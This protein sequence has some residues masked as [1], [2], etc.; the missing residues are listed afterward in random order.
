M[1][2]AT[3]FVMNIE[4]YENCKSASGFT[5]TG[6]FSCGLTDLRATGKQNGCSPP[7]WTGGGFPCPVAGRPG[8]QR[9][10][11]MARL[12]ARAAVCS[13]ERKA[14]RAVRGLRQGGG[15]KPSG[16]RGGRRR[17]RGSL[18]PY[19]DGAGDSG[20]GVYPAERG[21]PPGGYSG[22]RT[23]NDRAGAERP[24]ENSGGTSRPRAVY[25]DL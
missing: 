2:G 6:W 4:R 5:K 9:T 21:A 10:T 17:R 12:I 25:P 11:D 24:V 19:R 7:L 23:G 1:G 13:S 3:V 14:V 8:R 20:H 18:L 15:R 22:R 16:Y